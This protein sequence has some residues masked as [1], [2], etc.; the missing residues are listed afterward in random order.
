V[1]VIGMPLLSSLSQEKL[2]YTMLIIIITRELGPMLAAFVIIARSATAT[3]L[4]GMVISHE[5]V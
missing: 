3:E 2:I 1:Y 5:I 4:G